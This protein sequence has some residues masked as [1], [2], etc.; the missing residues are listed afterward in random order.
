MTETAA[1]V[2][3]AAAVVAVVLLAVALRRLLGA[4]EG[5]RQS[6]E[7]LRV[8]VEAIAQHQRVLMSGLESGAAESENTAVETEAPA[9]TR[10]PS[11]T[12]SEPA[13]KALALAAGTG[14]AARRLRN[15]G[16]V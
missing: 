13:I 9:R 3:A 4:V 15:R 1:W 6:V 2:A 12:R 14:R 5:V 7:S 8:D 10:L 16:A 11:V